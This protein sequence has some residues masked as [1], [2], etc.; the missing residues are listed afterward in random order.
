MTLKSRKLSCTAR[1]SW[2]RFVSRS[3]TSNRKRARRGITTETQSG[4]AATNCSSSCSCSNET[5]KLLQAE[6]AINLPATALDSG[7]VSPPHFDHEKLD[8][9]RSL[10]G[11]FQW[12]KDLPLWIE[13]K[14]AKKCWFA[15]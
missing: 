4:G 12:A 5:G 6:E 7:M 11:C 2:K 3:R 1:R 13:L 8:R 14:P 15:S 10:P 9:M